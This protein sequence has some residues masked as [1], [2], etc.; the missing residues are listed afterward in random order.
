MYRTMTILFLAVSLA[1]CMTDRSMSPTAAAEGALETPAAAASDDIPDLP[2]PEEFVPEITNPYLAF[3]R[4]RIFTYE[5]ETDE[6]LERN[7]IEISYRNKTILGVATT[8]V[9]D[10]V[11]VNGVLIESTE[12]WFAQ[13]SDGNVWYFGEDTKEFHDGEVTTEGSWEAGADGAVPGIIMLG[14]PKNGLTYQQEH[15]EGVAEDMAK[16]VGLS[17]AVET[18]LATYEGCLKTMEWTPLEP[19]ARELKF[20]APGV[21][22]VL[23]THKHGGKFRSELTSIQN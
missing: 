3:A 12:E 10:S 16:V 6:G 11:F 22:R 5:G 4:G 18:A 21:G 23:E 20:Y 13:D 9:L 8:V 17:V 19:G 2:P 15:A 7:T 14:E 1:G